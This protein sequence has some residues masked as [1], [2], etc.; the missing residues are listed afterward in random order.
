MKYIDAK[1]TSINGEVHI[2]WQTDD[3]AWQ[4]AT[5]YIIPED[6]VCDVELL[7]TWIQNYKDAYNAGKD[8][9]AAM[10]AIPAVPSDVNAIIN[11]PLNLE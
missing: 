10:A 11:Q 7:K 9:E 3:N 5:K 8:K 6:I 4:T 1:I 2:S